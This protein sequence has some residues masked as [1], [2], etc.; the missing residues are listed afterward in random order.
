MRATLLTLLAATL[1]AAFIPPAQAQHPDEALYAV[2]F[3]SD[4]CPNCLILDPEFDLAKSET[5]HLPIKHI[6]LDISASEE[7]YTNAMYAMMDRGMADLFNSYLGLTGVIFL[8]DP[9]THLP[10]GC[11][12]RRFGA[13]GLKA[14]LQGAVAA[15]QSGDVPPAQ[16]VTGTS[17]PRPMRALPNGRIYGAP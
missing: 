5:T 16:S 1:M 10:V 11:L 12:T 9:Q 3:R 13:D 7:V 17:C 15:V 6:T 2:Y 14:H 4:N 8:I